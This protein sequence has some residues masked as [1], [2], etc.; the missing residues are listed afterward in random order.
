MAEP[1]EKM[2]LS[3][4]RDDVARAR[5]KSAYARAKEKAAAMQ[6]A[7]KGTAVG[8]ALGVGALHAWKPELQESLGGVGY[9]NPALT[10]VGL[11]GLFALKGTM[12]EVASGAFMAGSIPP[13]NTLGSKARQHERLTSV[14][15]RSPIE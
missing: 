5:K 11:V 13:L 8:L 7:E 10:A 1:I 2:S 9:I 15:V 3:E 12:Q 14:V 4:L 6:L